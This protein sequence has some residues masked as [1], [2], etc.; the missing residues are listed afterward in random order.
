MAQSDI[1]VSRRSFQS[2]GATGMGLVGGTERP[3]LSLVD[4]VEVQRAAGSDQRTAL[5][6]RRNRDKCLNGALDAG[7]HLAQRTLWNEE[8]G[9]DSVAE[10]L[11]A[12]VRRLHLAKVERRARADE[13]VREFM[14]D[15][16]HPRGL[17]VGAV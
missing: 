11:H 14:R 3:K 1:F 12:I 13:D 16:K 17:R 2:F 15:G 7:P 10:A 8:L 6:P 4:Q 9:R 5:E